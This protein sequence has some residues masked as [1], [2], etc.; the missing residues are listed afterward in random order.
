ML[1]ANNLPTFQQMKDLITGRS[2]VVL[3]RGEDKSKVEEVSCQCRQEVQEK[4]FSMKEVS[5]HC[6]SMSCWVVVDNAVYDLTEFQYDHPG[7][8]DVILEHAGRDCTG[9]FQ[10]VG[11]SSWAATALQKYKIGMLNVEERIIL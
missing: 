6:D 8:L 9:V 10:D 4:L 2:D 7:G 11:H 5:R 3:P 1:L